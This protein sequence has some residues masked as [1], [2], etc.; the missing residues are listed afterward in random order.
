MIRAICISP[1][2][3]ITP[4]FSDVFA[5]KP[6]GSSQ[7]EDKNNLPDH[8]ACIAIFVKVSFLLKS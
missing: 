7:Y 6:N 4:Y 2:Q 5:E 3:D 8:Y 1:E